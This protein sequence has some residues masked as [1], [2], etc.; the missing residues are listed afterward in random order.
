LQPNTVFETAIEEGEL[1]F[2]SLDRNI[3][4]LIHKRRFGVRVVFPGNGC[5]LFVSS[6]HPLRV[7]GQIAYHPSGVDTT[8]ELTSEEGANNKLQSLVNGSFQAEHSSNT[9][10]DDVCNVIALVNHKLQRVLVAPPSAL[11]LID[12]P[13]EHHIQ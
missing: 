5:D 2:P 13:L 4:E 1:R 12:D 10:T 6:S 9:Y 3:R 7:V 8:V 11:P